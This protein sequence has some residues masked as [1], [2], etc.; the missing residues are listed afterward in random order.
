[1]YSNFQEEGCNFYFEENEFF[2][3]VATKYPLSYHPLLNLHK[4]PPRP[5][6]AKA[7]SVD[8]I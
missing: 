8:H 5:Q 2:G 3:R 6:A 1:M 4:I 7:G